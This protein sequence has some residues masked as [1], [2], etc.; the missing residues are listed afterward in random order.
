MWVPWGYKVVLD[1]GKMDRT[2]IRTC[3]YSTP[4]CAHK[5]SLRYRMKL[6]M[7]REGK[8]PGDFHLYSWVSAPWTS[9]TKEKKLTPKHE[10]SL[11]FQVRIKRLQVTSL[12]GSKG[13]E[14]NKAFHYSSSHSWRINLLL[15]FFLFLII[16]FSQKNNQN[17][18]MYRFLF[19]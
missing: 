13:K 18:Q 19:I 7:R 1:R 17:S 5:T 3:G 8:W 16:A 15:Y 6:D 10:V 4:P 2:Y 11:N 9:L 14:F 12:V